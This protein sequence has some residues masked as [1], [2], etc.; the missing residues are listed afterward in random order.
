MVIHSRH[1]PILFKVGAT[2]TAGTAR[3]SAYGL[4]L[5]TKPRKISA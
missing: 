2:T 1:C 3:Q 5:R 4:A